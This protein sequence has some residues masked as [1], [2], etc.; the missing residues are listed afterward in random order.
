V[1][2]R[3]NNNASPFDSKNIVAIEMLLTPKM[4]GKENNLKFKEFSQKMQENILGFE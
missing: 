1:L 4:A 3:R 2:H